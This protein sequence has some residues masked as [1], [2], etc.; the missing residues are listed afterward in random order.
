METADLNV[1][2]NEI[3]VTDR[4]VF[5]KDKIALKKSLKGK[6]KWGSQPG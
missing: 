5:G 3:N 4:K 6:L 2:I 1:V